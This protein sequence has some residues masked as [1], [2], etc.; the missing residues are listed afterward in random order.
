VVGQSKKAVS[1]LIVVL[2]LVMGSGGV[3]DAARRNARKVASQVKIQS[4]SDGEIAGSVSSPRAACERGRQVLIT[5]DGEDVGT[6]DTDEDGSW[7]T[8]VSV[9]DGDVVRASIEKVVVGHKG[10]KVVCRSDQDA[11]TAN[12]P[13]PSTHEVTVD[14]VGTGGD[15]DST[16][17]GISNCRTSSGT[18][19]G[20]FN[21]G[22][23]V[24]LTA[25]PDAGQQFSGWGGACAGTQSTCT[26]T[27][28]SDKNVTATFTPSG[29]GEEPDTCPVPTDVIEPIRGALCTVIDLL[30]SQA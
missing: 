10:N 21:R 12:I 19:T 4:I 2:C 22:S 18:C 15:V 5:V 1:L 16:P 7:A 14:V 9:E 26:L 24:T 13:E 8:E 17:G 30:S 11:R 29:G 27:M 28:N 3:A 20:D 6:T 23:Q 25:S